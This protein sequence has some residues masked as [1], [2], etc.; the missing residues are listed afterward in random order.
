MSNQI[1]INQLSDEQRQA[2]LNQLDPQALKQA[3]AEAEKREKAAKGKQL[4]SYEA[5]KNKV[6]TRLVKLAK[7]QE[8]KLAKLKREALDEIQALYDEM[9]EIGG[10]V[11][12]DHKGNLTLT[13]EDGLY[14]LRFKI[15]ER[16]HFNELAEA[17]EERL[18]R[19]LDNMVKKNKRKDFELIQ[20]LLE[21]NAATGKLDP[22]SVQKLYR[23]EDDFEDEDWK[24][25]IRL[26]KQAYEVEGTKAYVGFYAKDSQEQNA[27]DTVLLN[28]SAVDPS[29]NEKGVPHE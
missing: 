12:D 8:E 13:T 17:A 19:F 5:H 27:W 25:A 15:A 7:A 26:F 3:A 28:F 10:L 24:E 9:L 23:Y 29:P 18:K 22:R 14:R 21:R 2:L 4:K 16:Y 11:R 1:D 6:V 20:A